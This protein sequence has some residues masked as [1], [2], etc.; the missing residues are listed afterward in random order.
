MK[1]IF[2]PVI[3]LSLLAVIVVPIIASAA[4]VTCGN[5]PET[6]C[7]LQ[8]FL[9]MFNKIYSFIVIDLA[10]PLAVLA[11]MAGGIFI[12]ASAGNPNTMATGKKILWSGIIGMALTW[13]SY[14]IIKLVLSAIGYNKGI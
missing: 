2:L 14:A 13:G 11:V 4:I 8:D 7:T 3:L 6:P 12:M 9:G 5:T 1:K 10:T